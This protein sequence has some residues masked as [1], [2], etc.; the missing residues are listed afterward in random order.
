MIGSIA[1]FEEL[2][3]LREGVNFTFRGCEP[4]SDGEPT[5]Q[6]VEIEL[7]LPPLNLTTIQK[8]EA[9]LAKFGPADPESMQTI[10]K[11]IKYSLAR[12]YRGVPD[13]LIEQTL[14]LA[15]MADIMQSIMDVSGLRRKEI[16]AGKAQA[17]MPSTGTDSIAT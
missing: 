10:L 7:V 14:D 5:G 17:A 2:P 9:K 13:W 4:D 3:S 15:N 8:M 11:A 6:L 1:G 16:E 12:N